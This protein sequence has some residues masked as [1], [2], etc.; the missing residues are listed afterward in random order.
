MAA[1][2]QPWFAFYPDDHLSDER[3]VLCS[4]AA[5]GLWARLLCLMHKNDRR[6]YL[7]V[8]DSPLTPEQL[9]RASASGCSAE[10]VTRLLTELLHSGVASVSDTGVVYSRRMVREERK[11]RLC[12]EAG[13]KGG[14]N[15]AFKDPARNAWASRRGYVY[16]MRRARD[17]AVKVG[18][19]ANPPRRRAK[20]SGS[21]MREQTTLLRQWP[22]T[23]MGV[24]E[25]L[26]HQAFAPHH[27][28]GEWFAL[29]PE[30]LERVQPLLEEHGLA[31][32]PE[33]IPDSGPDSK[34][35]SN[36]ASNA[37]V[38]YDCVKEGET[39]AGNEIPPPGVPGFGSQHTHTLPGVGGVGGG[40]GVKGP[41][42]PPSNGL[43]G[44]FRGLPCDDPEAAAEARRVVEHYQAAVRPAHTR[45]GGV[46]A[47]L[48]L[49]LAGE[50]ADALCRAAEGYAAHCARQELA[51][52]HRQS[53]KRFYAE[54]TF[55]E[56]AD[57]APP[58]PPAEMSEAERQEYTRRQ[59]GL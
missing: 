21:L 30:D 11:R 5:Q 17:Q 46:E 51:P 19:S 35:A 16:A 52:R 26:L 3:L 33:S 18:A 44:G 48:A 28:L 24:A 38:V 54:G 56:Y 4:L 15:P 27:L 57:W 31:A 7:C 14:G 47:V 8:G 1:K 32:Q 6:G 58:R 12:S 53:V 36:G 22:V 55:G 42:K 59:L 20:G 9:A 40:G 37:P 39:Q 45:G 34:V 10:E 50:G 29:T 43:P 13:R 41:V 49:L 2:K 23:A 25:S